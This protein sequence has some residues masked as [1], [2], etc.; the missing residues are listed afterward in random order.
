[1]ANAAYGND[2]NI[3]KSETTEV[4]DEIVSVVDKYMKV[5]LK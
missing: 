5:R 3:D 1:M 4:Y 2:K